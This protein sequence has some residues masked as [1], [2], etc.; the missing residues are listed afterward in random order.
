MADWVV[1]DYLSKSEIQK[2]IRP[3]DLKGFQALLTTW[4]LISFSFF[5]VARYPSVGSVA[6]ALVILGGRHLALGIL[7][8]DAAHYSLFKTRPLND[9]IGSW[10]CAYPGLQ[11][12]RAYRRHHLQ[13]HKLAGS[14]DDPDLDLVEAYPVSR[15]SLFRK[16]IRDLTGITGLKRLYGVGL[17]NLGLIEYTV[18]GRVVRIEQKG[19]PSW[20][21]ILTGLK[22]AS[23]WILTNLALWGVLWG[24]G[25]PHLYLLWIISYMTTFSLFIRI[26]S[27]AE[28]ACT[29]VGLNPLQCTRT[30]HA[31]IS[32]RLTV[33]PHY[34]NYHLEHHI[35]MTVPGFRLAQMHQLLK[36]RGGL[37]QAFL[38][39]SYFEV[40]R[41]ASS[42]SS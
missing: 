29:D 20:Q 33:A 2:L 5:L 30:T 14:K 8:H 18:S 11:D 27:I 3:S 31:G 35:L 6:I 1:H 9:W 21:I 37:G 23:G 39:S 16:M 10:L 40:L 32:A 4:G 34:V 19:E 17:M 36:E 15:A 28:H 12:L 24:F 26:R 13:H 38:A 25:H 7:M 41:T 42:K 22:N